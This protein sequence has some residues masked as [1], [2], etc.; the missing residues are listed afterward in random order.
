VITDVAGVRVGHWT[1]PVGL[2]GCTVIL[3]PEGTVGSAEVRGGAPG[4]VGTDGLRPGSIGTGVDAVLLTGGSGFGLAAAVG[5]QRWLEEHG[6][7]FET[8]LVR[9]PIVA[10]AV[11]FDLGLGD[12]HARPDAASGYAACEAASDG[13]IAEGSV[14]AGTG[15]T[16]AKLPDPR[17]GMK[18]GLGSASTRYGDVI[19]GAVAAVN[20]LG[21]I[22]EADGSP[23][24]S[25]RG[26]ADAEPVMWPIQNTTLVCVAT[27]ARL[28]PQ[29][30][31][32]LTYAA[33][34]G[35]ALAVR[36]AH[37]YW[38]GDVAFA[39]ATGEVEADW[40]RLPELAIDA[41][42][43]AIRR[44]V[45]AATGAPGVPAVSDGEVG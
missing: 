2:T 7:G 21:R 40:S 43:D 6:R 17:K 8:G 30:A 41:V 39:L 23:L 16:V 14:G 12:P 31:L 10:G 18:G 20:A 26:D 36:P 1:D 3:T 13:P 22:V 33:H 15:A 37:T 5:V 28:S 38:D 9:V 11:L 29:H 45:R 24:A 4:T 19:V 34:D 35:L 25:N 42:A 27:N 32:R 44:G